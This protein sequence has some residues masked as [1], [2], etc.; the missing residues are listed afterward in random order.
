MTFRGQYI[1]VSTFAK[2]VKEN[3]DNQY[4][5]LGAIMG[6]RGGG[7]SVFGRLFIKEYCKLINRPF[8]LEKFT[9]YSKSSFDKNIETNEERQIFFLDE[10]ISLLFNRERLEDMQIDLIK[11]INICRYKGHLILCLVP[12]F[13]NLDKGIRDLVRFLVYVEKRPENGNPGYAHIFRKV[14][15]PF[16]T[17]PWMLKKNEKLGNRWF[18]SP[19]YYGTILITDYTG[20]DW[21]I[22]MEAEA[23][24]IKDEKKL[25]ALTESEELIKK[26]RLKMILPFY[27]QLRINQ[28]LK[29]GSMDVLADH[30]GMTKTQLKDK[31][32][33]EFKRD[34]DRAVVTKTNID[35]KEEE[36]R[37]IVRPNAQDNIIVSEATL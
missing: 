28:C 36:D 31:L 13:W 29:H 27:E 37:I 10:A 17:D 14:E 4:D 22:K 25:Q 34:K 16:V 19:N 12:I 2:L 5:G 3:I 15:S 9:Y 33:Y 18:K 11:K 8:E 1:S 20:E 23:L 6:E 30:L 35:L 7:K 32:F 26:D 24:K 21:F